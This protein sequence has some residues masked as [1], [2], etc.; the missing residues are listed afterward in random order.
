MPCA[1]DH[2]HQSGFV[3]RL[4]FEPVAGFLVFCGPQ[5]LNKTG[6][7]PQLPHRFWLISRQRGIVDACFATHNTSG[8]Q[9]KGL[10]AVEARATRATLQSQY[11]SETAKSRS[12]QDELRRRLPPPARRRDGAAARLR[13]PP[14]HVRRRRGSRPSRWPS[15]PNTPTARSPSAASCRRTSAS[16]STATPCTRTSTRTSPTAT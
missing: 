8:G 11:S 12:T 2:A 4:H 1:A 15:G 9:R 5:E 16:S 3:A 6:F 10:R 13:R 14:R 7:Q